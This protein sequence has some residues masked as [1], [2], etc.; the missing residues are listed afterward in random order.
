MPPRP[1]SWQP[2][3]SVYLYECLCRGAL[4]Q[5]AEMPERMLKPWISPELKELIQVYMRR[6][7]RQADCSQLHSNFKVRETKYE[8]EKKSLRG[9]IMP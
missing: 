8:S 6:E 3:N 7:I 5:R 4:P 1:I 9:I 2:L